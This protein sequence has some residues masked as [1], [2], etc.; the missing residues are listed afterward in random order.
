MFI[1]AQRTSV[2]IAHQNG[3]KLSE[4]TPEMDRKGW[5][6]FNARA[7]QPFNIGKRR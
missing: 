4:L 2:T 1:S 7:P 6:Q 5:T 3:K